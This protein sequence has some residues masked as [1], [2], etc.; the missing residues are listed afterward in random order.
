[1]GA[2][3]PLDEN[4]KRRL[5]IQLVQQL[6]CLECSRLYD[7]ED[8]ALV[9]RWGEVW[10]LSTRCRHC[11]DVCHVVIFMQLE[12]EPEPLT[13]LTPEEAEMMATL[14]PITADDVMD[15]HLL[16]QASDGDL[17]ELFAV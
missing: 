11:D 6:R 17:G 12:T 4:D 15:V 8:F 3:A 13:D 7:P 2:A 10:V 9:H 5:V 1:M 14:P 16:L